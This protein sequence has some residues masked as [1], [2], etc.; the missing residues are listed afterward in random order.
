MSGDPRIHYISRGYT[1]VC[2]APLLRRGEEKEKAMG[3]NG[4]GRLAPYSRVSTGQQTADPQLDALRAYA[5]ARGGDAAE[6]VDEGASGARA[7]RPARPRPTNRDR[8]ISPP[9][10]S[11]RPL[12][13]GRLSRLR[14]RA[15]LG[16]RGAR[17]TCSIILPSLARGPMRSSGQ[18]VAPAKN[19]DSASRKSPDQPKFLE[20]RDRFAGWL[21]AFQPEDAGLGR[22]RWVELFGQL[23]RQLHIGLV[24]LSELLGRDTQIRQLRG[25]RQDIVW[26]DPARLHGDIR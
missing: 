23:P 5:A 10:P 3:A 4:A 11:G 19:A 6:Y 9:R 14:L 8:D 12:V 22:F 13:C 16:Q 20:V 24:P 21:I 25:H 17:G 2:I 7:S 26:V 1:H 15:E 18:Y